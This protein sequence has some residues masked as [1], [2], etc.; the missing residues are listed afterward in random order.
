MAHTAR[1]IFWRIAGILVCGT[2]G[3][4]GGWWLVGALGLAGVPAALVG[5]IVGMV[6]ATAT[7]VALT[8]VLRK[9]GGQT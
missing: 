2:A 5:A 8:L 3:A 7:W 9:L 1:S 6:V 4:A